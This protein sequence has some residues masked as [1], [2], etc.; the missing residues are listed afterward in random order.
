MQYGV[1]LGSSKRQ[2]KYAA[3]R[4]SVQIL[5]PD[6]R[7]A[8]NAANA[9]NAGA[10]GASTSAGGPTPAVGESNDSDFD[11]SNLLYFLFFF[12]EKPT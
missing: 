12:M 10:D 8:P 2:A 6:M 11:V 7:P 1:G 3:V 5:I 4:A 9:G